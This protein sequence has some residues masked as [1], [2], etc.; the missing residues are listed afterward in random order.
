MLKKKHKPGRIQI[1]EL[2]T[3]HG[4][5]RPIQL[6]KLTGLSRQRIHS[7]LRDFVKKGVIIKKGISPLTFYSLGEAKK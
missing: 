5:L 6:H 2:L 4:T 3:E 1:I 7:L